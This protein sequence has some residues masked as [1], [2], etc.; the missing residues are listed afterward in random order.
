MLPTLLAMPDVDARL[1][2]IE[3]VGSALDSGSGS[4]FEVELSLLE[5]GS[6]VDIVFE[7]EL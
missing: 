5:V 3:V 6:G 1:V 7:V 2:T 4:V